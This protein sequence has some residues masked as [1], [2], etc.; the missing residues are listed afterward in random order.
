VHLC[1]ALS[2][3][4]DSVVL[5]TALAAHLRGR[6]RKRTRLRA[7][8]VHHGLHPNADA[9]TEHCSTVA[10]QLDVPLQILRIKV[11]RA[12]G[13]SLEAVARDARYA[14]LANALG[15]DEVL[16]TAHH[17][18]DQLE[19]VLLQLMRGSGVAGLAAMP[20]VAPFAQG[21]LVRPLLTR[22]RAELEAWR[23]SQT[24]PLTWVEDDT[25]ENE[26]LDRNYLRRR[27]LPGIRARWPSA[28]RAVSRSARHAAEAR[29]LLDALAL[30][31]V[32]RASNGA[33]LSVQH[34]R[35]LTSD[36]RRNAVRFWIARAGR[37]L[38]DTTRLDEITRTLLDA[39][40]DANPC[41]EWNGTRIQR[42]AN[43]LTI[44]RAQDIAHAPQRKR[45]SG[46]TRRPAPTAADETIDAAGETT[47]AAANERADAAADER[48]DAAAD[49]RADAAADERADAAAGDESR[50]SSATSSQ[51]E[52]LTWNWRAHSKIS[53]GGTRGALSIDRDPHGPINLDS[54]PATLTIRPRQGGE[55][56]RPKR[57]GPTKTLKSLLQQSRTSLTDRANIPLIFANDALIA[58]ADRWLDESIHAASGTRH[59]GRL[60]WHRA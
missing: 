3:G 34:L 40:D 11:A 29:R 27:V 39:R 8:H 37:P 17:E 43:L 44:E 35:T 2:G 25:N 42:H 9:W 5:L 55:R 4:L 23:R 31:D 47:A 6:L 14:A 26:Q 13:E 59:R 7:V 41:V 53:L 45:A 32:E 19:T 36:R 58:I 33:A 51:I 46:G 1:V 20:D 28:S 15:P 48:A 30:A 52:A 38:P 10:K 21:M 12:R 16:L 22:S 56:L 49:E 18:D 60:R 57:G 24:P 54:L 50:S